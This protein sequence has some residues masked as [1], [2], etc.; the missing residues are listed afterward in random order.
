MTTEDPKCT[1]MQQAQ[2][3]SPGR[4]R[5]EAQIFLRILNVPG[6]F[7]RIHNLETLGMNY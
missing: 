7:E 6:Y 1:A 2:R 4:S 3:I 5:S